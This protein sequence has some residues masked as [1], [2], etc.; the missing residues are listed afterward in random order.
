VLISPAAGTNLIA[1]DADGI[2]VSDD[3]A[4]ITTGQPDLQMSDSPT[5]PAV[6]ASVMTSTWQRDLV[7]VKCERSTTWTKR[8][9]AVALLTLA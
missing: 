2:V 1:I 3:G 7:A 5:D 4:E 6:A 8:A 9:T